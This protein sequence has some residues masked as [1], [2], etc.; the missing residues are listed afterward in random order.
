MAPSRARAVAAATPGFLPTPLGEADDILQLF[1]ISTDE[2]VPVSVEKDAKIRTAMLLATY[3][4]ARVVETI[5]L[6]GG[7]HPQVRLADDTDYHWNVIIGINERI[8]NYID[9]SAAETLPTD[10][11]I[12]GLGVNLFN[13]IFPGTVRRLY[14]VA[15]VDRAQAGKRLDIMITSMINWV[16][17]KPWEFAFDPNR[18]SFLATEAVNFTRNVLTAVPADEPPSHPGKP[19]RILVVVAQPIGLGLLSADEELKRGEPRL[20]N[21]ARRGPC[22]GGVHDA[23]PHRGS[24]RPPAPAG[25]RRPALHRSRRI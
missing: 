9:G 19:L 22:R 13:A 23:R 8:K 18:Q 2:H 3:R 5:F 20:S 10:D 6:R 1:L 17:D 4:N 15:R 11:E 25:Y 21:T 7:P 16:A 12:H 24:A 14:D